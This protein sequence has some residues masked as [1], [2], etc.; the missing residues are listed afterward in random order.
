MT[1]FVE[2]RLLDCVAYGF[3]GGPTYLTQNVEM[4]NGYTRRNALRSRPKY[5]F[6]A[7]YQNLNNENH[8]LVIAAFNACQGA[9]V[10]FRFKDWGDYQATAEPITTIV[11]HVITAATISASSTDNSF[12]DTGAG[13]VAAGFVTG[14]RIKT[15]I[16]GNTTLTYV[17]VSVTTTKMI[18]TGAVTT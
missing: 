1:S 8:A 18:V 17:V 10:G 3:Q 15:T 11:S 12:N 7:P 5:R 16:T 13:F 14:D 9:A 6:S 4:R 2:A